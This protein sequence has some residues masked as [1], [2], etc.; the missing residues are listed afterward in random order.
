MKTIKKNFTLILSLAFIVVGVLGL[1]GVAF[2][3][4]NTILEIIQVALGG[5][6][7]LFSIGK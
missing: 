3:T 2:F 4:S 1:I 7:L 6:G 5:I